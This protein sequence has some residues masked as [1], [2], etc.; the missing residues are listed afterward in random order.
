MK[1]K[2]IISKTIKFNGQK[3]I[4]HSDG[5]ITKFHKTSGKPIRTYGNKNTKQRY[6][7]TYLGGRTALVHRVIAQAFYG[8]HKY[9][10]HVDHID[11]DKQN[12]NPANLRYLTASENN[13]GFQSK[14]KNTSSIYRG[15]SWD[16]SKNKWKA[17]CESRINGKRVRRGTKGFDDEREA[18]IARDRIAFFE[19]DFPMEGLNFPDLFVDKHNQKSHVSCMDK[20]NENIERMQT[21][22][23][24]IR[25]E[26]RLLSYRIDRM[27]EQRKKLSEEKRQL[28]LKLELLGV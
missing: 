20:V 11:G 5:S 1:T 21:Q 23:E 25:S 8:K 13:K 12:N 3:V 10:F 16:I 4:C 26:S 14:K 7:R 17:L 6:M 19:F 22:I 28:K 18:A 24:M 15:V 27:T 2:E 9:N